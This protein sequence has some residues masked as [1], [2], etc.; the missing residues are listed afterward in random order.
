MVLHVTASKVFYDLLFEVSNEIRHGILLLLQKKA[1][2]I[3]DI[4][5]KMGL[6]NPEI[7]RHISR[8][9]GV[10]L[11]Q[12]DVE[13]FYHLT[14]FGET[15]LLLLLE[16]DFLSTNKEYFQTHTL[17]NVPTRFVK[18]IGEL[19]ASM[20]LANA[21]DFLRHTENLF[22]ELREFVWLLVDQFPLNSVSTIVEA[23]GRGVEFRFIEPKERIFTP[24]IDF[25]TSEEIQAAHMRAHRGII[26]FEEAQ[27]LSRTRHTPLVEQRM[28][29][30]VNVILYLSDARSVIAFPTSDGQFDYK[31]FTATDDF[32]LKWCRE[33]FQ[34]YWDEAIQRTPAPP[35]VQVKR[36]QISERVGL[37]GRVVIT[38]R[39]SPELDAQAVQ[40][41]VDNFDEVILRGT[42]NFGS[43]MVLISRSVVVRGEGRENDIP[44]TTIYKKGWRFPFTEFDS[45]FKVDDEGADVTIE[46]IQFTDFNSVCLWGCRGN[47]LNIKNNRITLTTGYGR[48]TT[49]GAFGDLVLGIWVE[50]PDKSSFRGGVTIEGNYLDFAHGG[51][52]WGGRISRG[53]LEEEPE[54]RP[55]LFNH[56][57][58]VGF[59][60]AVNALPSTVRIENN[61]VR[62]ANARGIA[63]SGHLASAD[64]QIR[65]NTV[66]SDVYGSYPFSSPEAGA[67]ILAQ[68]ALSSPAPGFNVE[69]EDN[70]I[71]L[72]KLNYSGIIVLGPATDR[73]GADKL[74]GGIIRNNRIQL[75]DGYEGVHVRKCDDFEVANNKISGEAYYG[76]RISGRRRSGE[77]DLRA[78]NNL[79]E[80][81]DMGNLQIRDP[82]EYSDNHSDG[83]MFAGS[84][85]GSATAH[86]WLNRYSKN[87]VVKIGKGEK[88]IDEGEDNS[89]SYGEAS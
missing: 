17:S 44:T 75:K 16:F 66:T 49:Y 83:R 63:I 34:Y 64:V 84:P 77:L 25:M 57:Y 4:T 31:G 72:D 23:I 45:V 1:M 68:S 7:R 78:L 79:V 88:V 43:S 65:H 9:R 8:L 71:K 70:T 89:I 14:P 40:D 35:A 86:V 62:N 55:D 10:G 61:I 13:G 36:E 5:K 85:I 6:N 2:R 28:V 51:F 52:I 39:E 21:M 15:A 41:A 27:A 38:G 54:Y 81:N 50:G 20:N 67:G 87:N 53:G 26:T 29:D 46:N 73:E 11:I 22:K 19:S 47:S 32:S 80:G 56:E 24:D 18:R 42:F 74:R 60:I 30:E 59:G 37:A 76:I 58:Y 82:D 3:T 12:R 33:L 48:G 69:I